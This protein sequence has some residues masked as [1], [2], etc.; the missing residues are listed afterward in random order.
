MSIDTRQRSDATE[1]MDDMEMTGELLSDT[2]DRLAQIN[3][4][5]GGN[6]I[7]LSAV[8]KLVEGH[9]NNKAIRIID[10]GCGNGDIV[11]LIADWGRTHGL[12]F[13]LIGIDLNPFTISHA[14]RLSEAYPEISFKTMDVFSQE[15]R[16]MEFDIA[17]ST[18]FLHHFKTSDIERL[19]QQLVGQAKIGIVINDLHR[20]RLAY[21]LFQMYSLSIRNSMIRHDGLISIL[22]A[23][24]S[25]ELQNMSEKLKLKSDIRWRWAFRYEWI[26]RID[27]S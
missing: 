24:K 13:E 4:Q 5:L 2:L 21:R 18:L 20:H 10:M 8:K 1:M 25:K 9:S 11:R 15:M 26:I 3:R 17:L 16:A 22:R 27:V 7:T 23:F 19:L 12:T 14:E 6:A